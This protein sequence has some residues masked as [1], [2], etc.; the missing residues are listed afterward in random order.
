[1]RILL[2]DDHRL[3]LEGIQRT[4]K[5]ADGMEVVATASSG[6]EALELV[7]SAHPDV[8]LLD[9]SMPDLDGLECLEQI[10]RRHPSVKVVMLSTYTDRQHIDAAIQRGA[11]A[12][13]VKSVDPVDLPAAVRLAC[14]GT[15]FQAV[16]A[17]EAPDL[18][19]RRE[20]LDLT[21]REMTILEAVARGLSNKAISKELWVTEQTVKFHLNNV[22]RKL[23]VDNRTAAVRYALDNGL[24]DLQ[25]PA[26]Q[27]A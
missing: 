2:A 5:D 15:M 27:P 7:K 6:C 23:G 1:M 11:S 21:E 25:E 8:V 24:L 19:A 16:G 9:I 3:T 26:R 18:N 13:V 14:E 20:K 12:Y 10:R 17:D 22:Y 4:F